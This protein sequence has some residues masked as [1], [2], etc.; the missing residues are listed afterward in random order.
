MEDI[1]RE[2]RIINNR[3]S[4]LEEKNQNESKETET[5][6]HRLSNLEKWSHT[7]IEGLNHMLSDQQDKVDEMEKNMK[8]IGK[9]ITIFDRQTD[10]NQR[11]TKSKQESPQPASIEAQKVDINSIG[12]SSNNVTGRDIANSLLL[13][14]VV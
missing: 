13:T 9:R 14:F 7:R 5:I 6:S 4:R 12:S 2:L 8:I 3:L 11:D 1:I 10:L